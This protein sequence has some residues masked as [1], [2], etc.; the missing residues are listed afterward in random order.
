EK[1]TAL[2]LVVVLAAIDVIAVD[3][4]YFNWEDFKY[5]QGKV[6]EMP[7]DEVDL[8]I[9]QDKD[10]HY[11]VYDVS[12]NPFNDNT[13]AA[14]HKLIGGYDPAKLSRYQDLIENI[15]VSK[16]YSDKGLDMLNCKYVI[17]MDTTKSR[18]YY[19]R[20]SAN[21]KAWFV[22]KLSPAKNATAEMDLMKN[23]D[24]KKEASV[25]SGFESN[26]NLKSATFVV[27]RNASRKLISY[28]PDTMIYKVENANPGYLVFSEIYYDNWRAEIDGEP[29]T[30][31]KVDY[32][33]RGLQVKPG[34][35]TIKLYYERPAE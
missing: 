26:K 34:A 22:E 8:A 35:H 16:E 11:R 9:Q 31:N 15:L 28:H 33:L 25:N 6:I 24:N 32:T 29:A 17:A 30:L 2:I 3:W 5:E 7:A 20:Y 19:P 18:F 14:H 23:I 10:P 13:A 4:R 27:D 21:G 12:N 1:S